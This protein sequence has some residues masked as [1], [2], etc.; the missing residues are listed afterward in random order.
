MTCFALCSVFT[1]SSMTHQITFISTIWQKEKKQPQNYQ[2]KKVDFVKDVSTSS[3][4]FT[5]TLKY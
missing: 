4:F 2:L 3:N 1:N 5:S